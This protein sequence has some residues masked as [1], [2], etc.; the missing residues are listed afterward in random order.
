M[1]KIDAGKCIREAQRKKKISNAQMMESFQCTKQQ[2]YRWQ[3]SPTMNLKTAH[4]FAK[5]FEMDI[6]KF[7][8]LGKVTEEV[9][10]VTS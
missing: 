8:K 4:E 5:Y 3:K 9:D 2:V 7:L 6:F 10:D 1:V